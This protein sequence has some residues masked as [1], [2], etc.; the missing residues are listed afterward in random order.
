MQV[1]PSPTTL[2]NSTAQQTRCTPAQL[3][4]AASHTVVPSQAS[5]QPVSQHLE[6]QALSTIHDGFPSSVPA[7][8]VPSLVSLFL[9]SPVL[10]SLCLPFPLPLFPFVLVQPEQQSSLVSSEAVKDSEPC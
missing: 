3:P 7:Q 6:P 8:S 9:A 2:L 4:Y 5:R 10:L 1:F